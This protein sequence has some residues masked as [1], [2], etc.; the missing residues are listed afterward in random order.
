VKLG[1]S[2]WAM[3]QVPIDAALAHIAA[4]GYTGV[5]ITVHKG[6]AT[7]IDGLDAAERKRIRA[8]V[9][10]LGLDLP[11]I[12]CPGTLVGDPATVATSLARV[13]ATMDLAVDWAGAASPPFVVTIPGGKPE[14]WDDPAKRAALVD[15]SAL[16]AA[17][18]EQRG[19]VFAYEA[20]VLQIVETP[21]QML[22]LMDEVKSPALKVNFD[23]SHFDVIG[24]PTEESVK[25]LVPGGRSVHTHLKDQ[26]G[27]SP[28]HEYL[29]PGE[30]DFDFV[31]YLRAMQAA[32][33][34]DYIVPE[35]SVMVQRR[36]TY[37]P[38]AAATQSFEVLADAFQRAGIAR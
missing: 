29:I 27:R 9:S 32:G 22:W 13:K 36:P 11:A 18:A 30:G 20:H 38:L 28:N 8:K 15:N 6:W 19:V 16:L 21:T 33:Y 4:T 14:D 7:D 24:I 23:I 2:T 34:D 12:T 37:D 10:A 25:A 26:R 3:P 5:E 31:A 17:Y 35:I 1:F